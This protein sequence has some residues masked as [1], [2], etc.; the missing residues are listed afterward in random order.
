MSVPCVC[1]LTGAVWA[2]FLYVPLLLQEAVAGASILGAMTA[3]SVNL[4]Q[5]PQAVMAAQAPG[6]ITGMLGSHDSA[7]LTH[8][9]SIILLLAWSHLV[10]I[11]SSM[12]SWCAWMLSQYV[13]HLMGVCEW[14]PTTNQLQ[15]EIS[16][17]CFVFFEPETKTLPRHTLYSLQ[18]IHVKPQSVM[19]AFILH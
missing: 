3:G 9:R 18:V 6:V 4:P 19:Y 12:P 2:V 11:K 1:W 7:G 16:D 14:G 17:W 8:G 13:A 15:S 5:I 10:C